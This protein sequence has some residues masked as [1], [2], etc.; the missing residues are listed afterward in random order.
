MSQLPNGLIAFGPQA[1]CTLELCP[2][3]WSILKYQPSQ[4]ASG[5]F[6]GIFG[7][8]LLLH[9]A[10]GIWRRTWG[11]MVCMVCGCILEIAGYVGRLLIHNNP[12][13]FNGFIMQIGWYHVVVSRGS[14][15]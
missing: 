4:A 6:I 2:I 12:F 3:E 14:I 15:C 1:N 8:T 9:A 13:D 10:Q 11:F 7:L 5:V